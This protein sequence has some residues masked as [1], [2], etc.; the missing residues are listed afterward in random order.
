MPGAAVRHT[1]RNDQLSSSLS[2]CLWVI[3]Q[4]KSSSNCGFLGKEV[5]YCRHK[6]PTSVYPVEWTLLQCSI[7]AL[8]I[9]LT[10]VLNKVRRSA[11]ALEKRCVRSS[12]VLWS[13]VDVC[14]YRRSERV[15]TLVTTDTPPKSGGETPLKQNF[16]SLLDDPPIFVQKRRQHGKIDF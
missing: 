7:H 12:A 15:G 9:Q 3:D 2:L 11:F 4:W 5:K 10:N 1:S 8:Q 13:C 14:D 16:L 6:C